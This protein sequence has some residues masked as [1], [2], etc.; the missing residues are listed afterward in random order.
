MS[1]VIGSYGLPIVL[2]RY[3]DAWNRHDGP[4]I[5]TTFVSGGTYTDPLTA[6]SLIG[7]TIARYAEGLWQS[8]P[9]LRFELDG[10]PLCNGETAYMPWKMLGT[11]TGPF[12][13]LPPS[14]KSVTVSGVD[15]VTLSPKGLHSVVGYFDSRVVPDQLGLQV[16]VQ[17]RSIG[18]FTFGSST[19]VTSQRNSTRQ[20]FSVTSIEPRTAEE[21]EGIRQLGREILKEM[22]S[23]EGFIAATTVTCGNRQMT[24]SAWESSEYIHQMRNSQSH[25]ESMRKF[26]GTELSAGGIIGLWETAPTVRT[27]QR[28]PQ[29]DKMMRPDQGNGQCR[30]GASVVAPSY[31]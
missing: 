15:I 12:R 23:M 1:E 24:F 31:W 6:G 13:G 5:A 25:N 16:L 19:R 22:L 4:G 21:S 2:E 27:F 18:P 17:P 14:G 29:C 30:C 3:I 10:T 20:A 11:N 8:F 9:D 26:F 28:C 7:D